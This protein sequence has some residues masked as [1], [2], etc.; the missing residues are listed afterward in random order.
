MCIRIFNLLTV[1]IE[2][3]S[4]ILETVGLKIRTENG[5]QSTHARAYVHTEQIK[6]K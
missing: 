4:L 3:N 2:I 6:I 5:E 1:L